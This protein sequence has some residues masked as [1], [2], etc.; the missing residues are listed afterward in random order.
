MS[1]DKVLITPPG[2]AEQIMAKTVKI[3]MSTGG[4]KKFNRKT[5][6][7]TPFQTEVY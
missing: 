6:P 3:P 5:P 2:R 7:K 4:C 1:I